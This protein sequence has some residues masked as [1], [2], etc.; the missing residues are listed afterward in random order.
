[1]SFEVSE[2]VEEAGEQMSELIAPVF[3]SAKEV[4]GYD[5]PTY[6]YRMP[7]EQ[8]T[9]RAQRHPVIIVGCIS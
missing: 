8:R 3:M 9:G 4:L 5:L 6:L 1:M 2:W 7:E